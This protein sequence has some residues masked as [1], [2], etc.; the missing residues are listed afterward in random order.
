MKIEFNKKVEE[1]KS[2]SLVRF[3][4]KYYG[5]YLTDTDGE[6]PII[7]D[8]EDDVYYI[9]IDMRNIQ[10]VNGDVKLVVE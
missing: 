10:A 1:I 9:D 7:Y 4:G 5:I 8:L 2:G 6:N 3:D